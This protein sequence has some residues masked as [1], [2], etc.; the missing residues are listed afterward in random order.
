MAERLAHEQA[1]LRRVAT[2]VARGAKTS[3]VFAAV[4]REVAEVMHLPVAAVQRYDDDGE[5]MTMLAAWG[6]R[7][8]P[9][10]PGTRWPLR[11]SGLAAC[12][13]Q[14]GRAAGPSSARAGEE[15]SP[16]RRARSGAASRAP[17]SSSTAP[18]GD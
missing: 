6:D 5:T 17:R 11:P 12:V 15:P 10:G 18:S 3:E 14:T 2:L 13:R 8:H 9:F 7:P 4:A 1:A 16:P